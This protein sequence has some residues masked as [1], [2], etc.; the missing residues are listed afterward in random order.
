[1]RL[2]MTC[3]ALASALLL[4]PRGSRAGE[5]GYMPPALFIG[6]AGE[7]SECVPSEVGQEMVLKIWQESGTNVATYGAQFGLSFHNLEPIELVPGAGFTNVG[8][9]TSPILVG[10]HPNCGGPPGWASLAELQVRVLDPSGIRVC[11]VLSDQDQVACSIDC[12]SGEYVAVYGS[13]FFMGAPGCEIPPSDACY[14]SL[15]VDPETWGRI[16]SVY[17][18]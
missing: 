15:P 12:L 8:T 9:M 5:R 13:G 1:M 10:T 7:P 6:C 3:V 2:A 4:L 11:F 16:K 18:K 17:R 14:D